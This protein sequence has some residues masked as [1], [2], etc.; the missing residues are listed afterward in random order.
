LELSVVGNKSVAC[1]AEDV[2]VV[3]IL[4]SLAAERRVTELLSTAFTV[5]AIFV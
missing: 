1:L 5:L 3:E 4:V 2:V